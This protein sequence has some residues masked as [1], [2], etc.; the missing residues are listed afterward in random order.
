M[1]AQEYQNYNPA[2]IILP[3]AVVINIKNITFVAGGKL[4]NKPKLNRK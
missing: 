2:E 4:T 1:K 3:L